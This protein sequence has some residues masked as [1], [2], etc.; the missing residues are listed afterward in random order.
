MSRDGLFEISSAVYPSVVQ[1]RNDARQ[2]L[3]HLH[4]DLGVGTNTTY[5]LRYSVSVCEMVEHVGFT[6]VLDFSAS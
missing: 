2:F 3:R 1:K 5:D 6:I 4:P